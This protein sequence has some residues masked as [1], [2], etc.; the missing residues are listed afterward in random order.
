MVEVVALIVFPGR[1]MFAVEIAAA[2]VGFVVTT[3][4]WAAPIER[5]LTSAVVTGCGR[6]DAEGGGGKTCMCGVTYRERGEEGEEGERGTT[7]V[8]AVV[9]PVGDGNHISQCQKISLLSGV[10]G[11]QALSLL[12]PLMGVAL[13]DEPL[14]NYQSLPVPEGQLFL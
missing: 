13:H 4:T 5:G 8:E 9:K 12:V 11:S 1:E 14:Q 3:L 7:T 2:V 10:R 6:C